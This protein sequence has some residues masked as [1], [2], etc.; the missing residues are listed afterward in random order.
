VP[1]RTVSRTQQRRQSRVRG[2]ISEPALERAQLVDRLV[3]GLLS[4]LRCSARERA[5]RAERAVPIGRGFGRKVGLQPGCIQL[6]RAAL[7]AARLTCGAVGSLACRALSSAKARSRSSPGTTTA[8]PGQVAR[9][10]SKAARSAST[11][12][13]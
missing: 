13:Q 5:C 2:G 7:E 11:A 10:D 12:S 6:F 1:D 8:M 3:R 9:A 4:K